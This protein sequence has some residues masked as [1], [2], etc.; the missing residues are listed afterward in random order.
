MIS[1]NTVQRAAF[2]LA[3][4]VHEP[5]VPL[6]QVAHWQAMLHGVSGLDLAVHHEYAYL[7]PGYFYLGA[8]Q[9]PDEASIEQ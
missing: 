2:C 1:S 3:Y 4:G 6:R 9:A 8:S 7:A 5:C